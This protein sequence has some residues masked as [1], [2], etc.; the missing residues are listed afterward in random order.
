VSESETLVRARGL[1]LGYGERSVLHAVDLE[2]RRGEM[3][4]FI[5]PNGTGKTTLLRALLGSLEPL[6]GELWLDP[7]LAGR[8]R[9]GYVPQ[10]LELKPTLPT[11]VREF[12]SL[13]FVG[14]QVPRR[15]RAAALRSALHNVG[16]GEKER[17]SLRALSGGQRQRALVARALVRRPS[18][19]MVDEPTEGLDVAAADAFRTTV[20]ELNRR[21][22]LTLIFVTH[23]LLL[24]SRLAT[25]VALFYDGRVRTGRAEALL[26]HD[27]LERA[28][29]ISVDVAT[30]REAL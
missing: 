14:S 16:L 6:A 2:V 3:W 17:A 30:A 23:N 22:G 7:Q 19:L 11:T 24:A 27:V 9:Q 12:A 20:S 8:E 21:D 10:T 18:L 28:F 1:D 5:G 13:G 25:H 15:E 29:G 26:Q 4:F